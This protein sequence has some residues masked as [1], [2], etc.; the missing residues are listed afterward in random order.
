MKK[1]INSMENRIKGQT[2]KGLILSS[3]S[4]FIFLFL[5]TF[6]SAE[7]MGY[8]QT[9]DSINYG[10]N[11]TINV[12]NSNYL[13]GYTPLTLRTFFENTLNNL[14]NYYSKTDI[15][16]FNASYLNATNMSYV[17][18][19]GASKNV[20]LGIS[21]LTA[22][23][24]NVT[25]NLNVMGKF[26]LTGNLPSAGYGTELV[27]NGVFTD[28]TGWTVL[29]NWIIADGVAHN[30]N[31]GTTRMHSAINT[32][33]G[34]QYLITFIAS[35]MTGSPRLYFA[36]VA[37]SPAA[38]AT[39]YNTYYPVSLGTNTWT[40]T[41]TST[42]VNLALW[43]GSVYAGTFDMDNLSIIEVLSIANS[44]IFTVRTNLLYINQG[45][46]VGIGTAS[47]LAKLNLIG[48][49]L[50]N[51]T[52]NVTSGGSFGGNVGIGTTNPLQKLNVIGNILV[53]GTINA[54]MGFGVNGN[55]G[56]TTNRHILNSSS[57][58]CWINYTGG[59]MTWSDC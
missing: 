20:T 12:N 54:T 43:T 4:I 47:P 3:I 55:S 56:L 59:L 30:Y 10:A 48:N 8:G 31:T 58:A 26:D 2:Y 15:N 14:L 1:T 23:N 13:Q 17:P 37:G 42:P 44:P 40:V 34:K 29:G 24:E 28:G 46:N 53:N 21:N 11:Y 41:A 51:G 19:T 22:F 7:S 45:G 57:N 32:E 6:I 52:M 39:P 9:T 35:N 27:S 5:I 38:F 18:Y 36:N 25:S 50:V 49:M 16:N 33:S